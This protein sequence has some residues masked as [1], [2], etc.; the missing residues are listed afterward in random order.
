M[1]LNDILHTVDE[2]L[3]DF[4]EISQ[5]NPQD[6]D[7]TIRL[8]SDTVAMSFQPKK[9]FKNVEMVGWAVERAVQVVPDIIRLFLEGEPVLTLRGCVSCGDTLDEVKD[10]I[11][12]AVRL[13]IDSLRDHGES[14]PTPST[15]ATTVHAA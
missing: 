12:E 15:T 4:S 9:D 1:K 3:Q 11:Q 13:H 5:T 7:V 8:L 14:I 10:L 2:G 6:I